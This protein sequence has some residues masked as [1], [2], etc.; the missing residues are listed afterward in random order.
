M[1]T[2]DI[3]NKENYRGDLLNKI[4]DYSF[5]LFKL[6]SKLNTDFRM[7]IFFTIFSL[8]FIICC[9]S[10]KSTNNNDSKTI[11][12]DFNDLDGWVDGSQNN[13]GPDN[14][15]IING[16]LRIQTLPQSRERAKVRTVDKKYTA[17][18]FNWRVYL[19]VMGIGDQASIGAFIYNDDQH[20]LDFEVGYGKLTDR[21]ALSAQED[22]LVLF[23]TSQDSPYYSTKHLLKR[24]QWYTFAIELSPDKINRTYDA[25]WK[26]NDTVIDETHLL[27]GEEVLFYIFCSVENL[28]FLGDH[29]PYQV[30]YAL[31]DYVEYE[32]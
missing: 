7:K 3:F 30:N 12:W 1:I 4:S 15:E 18:R 28:E 21:T 29:I 16:Q 27:Y 11:L 9:S 2:K 6:P 5:S 19:P 22:D 31:F 8:L 23:T 13:A 32:P 20:E 10:E 17:G 14:Y 24:E 25:T 26:V